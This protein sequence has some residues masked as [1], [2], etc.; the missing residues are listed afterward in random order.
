M[1]VKDT[2]WR[3]MIKRQKG[4]NNQEETLGVFAICEGMGDRG[5]SCT[6]TV[7]LKILP[8]DL[9]KKSI[10]KIS[11]NHEYTY[12][13]NFNGFCNFYDRKDKIIKRF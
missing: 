7:N 1:H 4:D 2:P 9:T 5:W 12:L 11:V 10:S 13:C 6:A 3:I 8:V